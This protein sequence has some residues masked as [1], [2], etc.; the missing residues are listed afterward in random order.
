[1]M[2]LNFQLLCILCGFYLWAYDA[3]FSDYLLSRC[4]SGTYRGLKQ[5]LLSWAAKNQ[6][7]AEVDPLNSPR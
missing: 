5:G 2:G 1:M 7:S 4:G 6:N 3:L